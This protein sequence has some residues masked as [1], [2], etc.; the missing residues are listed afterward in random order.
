MYLL[1]TCNWN[2]WIINNP[3]NPHPGQEV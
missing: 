1:S 2:E 3:P